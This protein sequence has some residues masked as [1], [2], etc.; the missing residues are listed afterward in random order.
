MY[1]LHVMVKLAL[2]TDTVSALHYVLRITPFSDNSLYVTK[3]YNTTYSK[4]AVHVNGSFIAVSNV[5]IKL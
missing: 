3:V 5:E 2:L 4:Q 1:R